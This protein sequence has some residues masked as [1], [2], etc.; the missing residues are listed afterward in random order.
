MPILTRF[1]GSRE[2]KPPDPSE[3]SP[4][5]DKNSWKMMAQA[6]EAG[7]AS[8]LW[9]IGDEID[10]ALSGGY[11]G[12]I[13]LQIAGFN[14][15]DLAKRSGKAGITFLSKQLIVAKEKMNLT[16]TAAGGWRDSYMRNTVMPKIKSSLPQDLQKVIKKVEKL[17]T[18]GGS[19]QVVSSTEDDLFI[20]SSVEA[21]GFD[22]T[23]CPSD[24]GIS[25]KHVSDEGIKYQIF[26]SSA[27]LIKNPIYGEKGMW[28][29]RSTPYSHS[30]RDIGFGVVLQTGDRIKNAEADGGL[31]GV[32]LSGVCFGFCI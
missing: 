2:K 18:T 5:L 7:M 17:S 30:Y 8:F 29:L 19:S 14:H 10:V 32:N 11:N 13:T 27:D 26:K 25:S 1:P 23:I 16:R 9:K 20:P 3:L 12:T 6:S 24:N 21:G 31:N 4:D 28:W 15:D 22:T